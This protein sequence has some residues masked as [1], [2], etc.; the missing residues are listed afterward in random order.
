MSDRTAVAA[1]GGRQG[2]ESA[3]AAPLTRQAAPD[4]RGGVRVAGLTKS[5]GSQPVLRGVDLEVPAGS[6]TAVLGPSGSGKT[7]LLRLLAGFDRADA[8]M[9]MLGGRVAD[10]TH[11]FVRPQL[12]GVGYVPQEGALFP[13]L[14][15]SANVS[16]GVPRRERKSTAELVDLVGL[17]GLEGRYP[18]QLSGGQQ[19]RVA[20]ARALA[21]RPGVVLLD[22]PFSSLDASLRGDVR[23]DVMAILAGRG[24][25][26]VLV[27]HDQDEALATADRIAVLRAGEIVATAD[28]RTL[29]RQ[30]PD[31]VA[32]LSI[33]EAN[34]LVADVRGGRGRCALGTVEV[35][36]A[37][38]R[39]PEGPAQLLLRPEQLQI[40]GEP[41]SDGVTARVDDV[42]FHGH[43]A[44]LQLAL[45]G[46]HGQALVARVPGDAT[47]RHG[48]AVSVSVRGPG[49]VW[50]ATQDGPGLPPYVMGANPVD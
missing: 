12:R 32:A 34:V 17:A 10:D 25:T 13:H 38:G 48:D 39:L 26:T 11:R 21:V 50:P 37:D 3:A 43:D 31:L 8:G 6:I 27:T 19:Q 45:G 22:E 36:V 47:F 24:A 7:T 49:L 28:P 5:F 30:P 46:P 41:G 2:S 29:Y 9:I 4:D 35:V 23:R 42:Q 18:H 1:R 33:G 16:F 20:L 15:V 44:V 14:T 40:S